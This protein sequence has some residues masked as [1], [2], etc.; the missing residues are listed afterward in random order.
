MSQNYPEVVNGFVVG[1]GFPALPVTVC[2]LAMW[3]I[4]STNVQ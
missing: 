4:Y 2:G 3:R 1:S